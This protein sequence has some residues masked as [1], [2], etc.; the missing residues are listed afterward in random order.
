MASP[1]ARWGKQHVDRGV[2]LDDLVAD[3][4]NHLLDACPHDDDRIEIALAPHE[5]AGYIGS[6]AAADDGVQPL[7][8]RMRNRDED[9]VRPYLAE[10]ALDLVETAQHGNALH[11]A[12]AQAGVVVDEADNLFARSLA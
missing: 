6:L 2:Q 4:P 10:H 12:A 11:P 5:A 7:A 9:D 3:R 8:G 1:W